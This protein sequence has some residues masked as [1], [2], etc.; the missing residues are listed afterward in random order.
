[1]RGT[2]V[3][4]VWR[5]ARYFNAKY[6]QAEIDAGSDRLLAS[7]GYAE[8]PRYIAAQQAFAMVYHHAEDEQ[9][10]APHLSRSGTRPAYWPWA[11]CGDPGTEFANARRAAGLP[12]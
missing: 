10:S 6:V 4:R 1:M 5:M 8:H 12:A 11:Y 3:G 7:D 2:F 9:R